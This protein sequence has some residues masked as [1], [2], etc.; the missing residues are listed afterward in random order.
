MIAETILGLKQLI[1]S[2]SVILLLTDTLVNT[3]QRESS[4]SYLKI[5]LKT[6]SELSLRQ[7][8]RITQSLLHL[9]SCKFIAVTNQ[10]TTGL[11]FTTFALPTELQ[12][13]Y[14]QW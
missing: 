13:D 9:S 4:L 10:K 1:G 12:R 11:Y 2:C 7:T 14:S 3:Y 6:D 8:L 5:V